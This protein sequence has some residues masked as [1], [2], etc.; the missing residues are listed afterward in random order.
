MA[1]ENI[2]DGSFIVESVPLSSSRFPGTDNIP[3][4]TEC[5]QPKIRVWIPAAAGR[6]GGFSAIEGPCIQDGLGLRSGCL[7]LAVLGC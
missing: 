7:L 2:Q 5:R 4:S 1:S 6:T 3:P